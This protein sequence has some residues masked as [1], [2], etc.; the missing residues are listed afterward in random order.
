MHHAQGPSADLWTQPVRFTEDSVIN[1]PAEVLIRGV[2]FRLR[3]LTA[4]PRT[5]FVRAFRAVWKHLPISDR[6][7]LAEY[8]ESLEGADV[9]LGT[10][11][12]PSPRM[13]GACGKKGRF[14][15]FHAVAVSEMPEDVLE[16][17]IA[18]ELM[19]LLLYAVGDMHH[20]DPQFGKELTK[21]CCEALADELLEH[22]GYSSVSL[23]EWADLVWPEVIQLLGIGRR[24]IR[25]RAS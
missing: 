20:C 11:W 2:P 12:H 17:C 19:H 23:R 15:A 14:L 18:H 3:V 9:V 4:E 6:D 8:L 25:R 5:K 7:L 22:H 16:T 21:R 10:Q 13:I 24:R 1:I